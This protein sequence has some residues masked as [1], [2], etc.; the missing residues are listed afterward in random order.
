MNTGIFYLAGKIPV[1]L[2]GAPEIGKIVMITQFAD[3][4]GADL[5]DIR[6]S[7]ETPSSFEGGAYGE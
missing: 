4:I 7:A 1:M 3:K 2:M 5:I 6:L